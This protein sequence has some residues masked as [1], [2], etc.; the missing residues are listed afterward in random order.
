MS[1]L[2]KMRA[3]LRQSTPK[4]VSNYQNYNQ[5]SSYAKCALS[6]QMPSAGIFMDGDFTLFEQGLNKRIHKA[7]PL[8]SG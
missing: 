4:G 2:H 5:D 6:R 3:C 8:R 1:P 7:I